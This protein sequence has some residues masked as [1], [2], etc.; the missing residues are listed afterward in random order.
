MRRRI[1]GVSGAVVIV[2]VVL[3]PL[4]TRVP[5]P[6]Q[7]APPRRVLPSVQVATAPSV[8]LRATSHV[9]P[10]VATRLH[11]A[12]AHGLPFVVY[13]AF[14][15]ER[16]GCGVV[17]IVA[18][19]EGACDQRRAVF[20]RAQIDAWHQWRREF[21]ALTPEC[22]V[23]IAS[24][25]ASKIKR[26]FAKAQ[27][28]VLEERGGASIDRS[29]FCGFLMS[30]ALIVTRSSVVTKKV[31]SLGSSIVFECPAPLGV[32]RGLAEG[33]VAVTIGPTRASLEKGHP[34]MDVVVQ[35]NVSATVA[36]C[37]WVKG[38]TYDDRAGNGQ[39]LPAARVAEWLAYHFALGVDHFAIFDNSAGVYRAALDR[40]EDWGF[41]SPLHPALAPLVAAG[42][43]THVPWPTLVDDERVPG[44]ATRD[45]ERRVHAATNGTKTTQSFFGRPSQYA[46]QNACHRRLV[47]AGASAV[48]H[49]DVDEFVVPRGKAAA[50][51]RRKPTEPAPPT[52]P[53]VAL[54]APILHPRG[55]P[56]SALAMP[57]VFY[58][59]C[60]GAPVG[61][62]RS[63]LL[64]DATCA[65]KATMFRQKLI[66]G[67]KALSLWV[68]YV[69]VAT[70]GAGPV[71][72]LS[73][74]DVILA[75]LRAGYALADAQAARAVDARAPSP[76]EARDYDRFVAPRF[77]PEG[78]SCADA[79]AAML[80]RLRHAAAP[81]NT[82]RFFGCE[83]TDTKDPW[84]W[85]WCRDSWPRRFAHVLRPQLLAL[86]GGGGAL[87][88]LRS[89][90]GPSLLA[91]WP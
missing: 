32:R 77:R 91:A 61:A 25:T 69:R 68:H 70:P 7:K 55:P 66:A 51:L 28:E 2:V 79:A 54:A 47:A 11:A 49:V 67:P 24:K 1:L 46:A 71:E 65:G 38:G 19:V 27:R 84:G 8:V 22:P 81:E 5:P 75:H 43:A 88:R 83:R 16:D 87:D 62:S 4:G 50:P 90:A 9:I 40:E 31:F 86:Y 56:P 23:C 42:R 74:R 12:A 36:A 15:A 33:S 13:Q 37:A 20:E 6:P 72:L 34:P 73:Y 76:A 59:P 17:T 18:Q 82:M 48:L 57:C 26:S 80:G 21:E 39:A 52:A 58:A 89:A 14:C 35:R 64:D 10:V 30:G 45:L 53:L 41:D 78:P 29:Y 63:L 3:V 60:S 85:C 44:C